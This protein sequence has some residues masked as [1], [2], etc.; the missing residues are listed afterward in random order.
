MVFLNSKHCFYFLCVLIAL[1]YSLL[2][3][4]PTKVQAITAPASICKEKFAMLDQLISKAKKQGTVRVIINLN[5]NFE[6]E[7]NLPSPAQAQR[8]IASSQDTLL[9]KISA[10]QPTSI[11]KFQTIPAL[12]VTLNAQALESL[13]QD[14]NILCISEDTP[15]APTL[16]FIK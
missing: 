8:A 10:Y 16:D 3:L 2:F 5:V 13:K 11:R 14:S 9:S 12:A 15:Q 1:F 6:A 4:K 7:G